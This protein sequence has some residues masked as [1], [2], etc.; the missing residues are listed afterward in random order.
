MNTPHAA[1]VTNA[2][3]VAAHVGYSAVSWTP[4]LGAMTRVGG[5]MDAGRSCQREAAKGGTSGQGV[6]CAATRAETTPNS[7]NTLQRATR[8]EDC[9]R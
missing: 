5:G 7:D 4:L 8:D 6:V 1:A 3:T 2:R 9:D